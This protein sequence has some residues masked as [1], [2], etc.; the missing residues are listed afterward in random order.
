MSKFSDYLEYLINR[1]GEPIST[2]ARGAHVERTSIHKAMTGERILSYK[3][4]QK[5]VE[6][7]RLSPHETEIFF[8]Y[9]NMSLQGETVFE[10]RKQIVRLLK[11]LAE[12]PP[13]I[14]PEK[15][16]DF[17]RLE[18]FPAL[19][20]QQL[21]SGKFA[22]RS[23]IRQAV[24][25][26]L[27]ADKPETLT[28]IPADNGFFLQYIYTIFQ[29][30]NTRLQVTH[31][32]PYPSDREHGAPAGIEILADVLSLSLSAGTQYSSW[33]YYEGARDITTPFPYY[34][35]TSSCL[36]CIERDYETVMCVTH[37]E[38][39]QYYRTFFSRTLEQ[40]RPLIRFQ[41]TPFEILEAYSAGTSE[42]SYYTFMPQ[43]CLG[44]FYTPS[45]IARRLRKEL[46]FYQEL[47][48]KSIQ[49]FSVL[50]E[51][52]EHY[53]TFF[54][55]KGISAFMENGIFCDIPRQLVS[56]CTMEERK[57]LL[58]QLR[59]DIADDRIMGRLVN[60]Q[61]FVLPSNLSFCIS[62]HRRLDI[63]TLQENDASENFYNIHIDESL[64]GSAFLDF[65]LY[66][67]KSEYLL[68]K[69]ETLEALD[70]LLSADS[71]VSHS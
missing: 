7:L 61:L 40:C 10:T 8:E 65:I 43:P 67:P 21:Y 4:A 15:R 33:F 9:M 3:S 60:D 62:E 64:I 27:G 16:L 52:R 57:T 68:S 18:A 51:I 70:S 25:Q 17:P 69:D 38:I 46:P 66:L 1:N 24:D 44:R 58:K 53:Y 6:Y 29:Q 45:L 35:L 36:L 12:Q 49:R 34:L 19:K 59:D 22:V 26:E 14:E 32:M 39:L 55:K 11:T 47:V 20:N 42:N 41:K 71:A 63:F 2:L 31:I 30:Y 5:L 28:N 23:M 54:T 56:P 37:S 50:H 13:F 48:E